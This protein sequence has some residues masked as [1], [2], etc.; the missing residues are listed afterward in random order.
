MS[1]LN[2]TA[3][4]WGVGSEKKKKHEKLSQNDVK[5][6]G[7][8]MKLRHFSLWLDLNCLAVERIIP[9]ESLILYRSPTFSLS[10]SV[11]RPCRYIF[12]HLLPAHEL[13]LPS[14][15][16]ELSLI[17]VGRKSQIKGC[18]CA[19]FLQEQD[20]SVVVNPEMWTTLFIYLF[21]LQLKWKLAALCKSIQI[22][23]M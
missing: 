17:G 4:I 20:Y 22:S 11:S 8:Q 7:L 1:I 18:L 3:V 6:N 10:P 23:L 5:H 9:E 12:I 14:S 16:A 21:F 19:L 13:L 2:V 15:H